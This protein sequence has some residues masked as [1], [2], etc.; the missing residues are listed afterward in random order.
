MIANGFPPLVQPFLA[1]YPAIHLEVVTD[2]AHRDIISGRFDAGIR[3]GHRIERDMTIMRML[4]EFRMIV[5]AAPDYLL[6]RPKPFL[7]EDLHAHNCIRYRSPWEGTILPWV[8]AK[9][10]RRIEIAVE[11]PLIVS[12]I[13][14]ILRN[15]LDGVGIGYLPE[16][17]VAAHLAQGRLVA[18]LDGWTN[19]LPGIFLYH[20]SRRQTPM[21]LEV[22]LRFVEKWR[23]RAPVADPVTASD[24]KRS[25]RKAARR[26]I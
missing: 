11:G 2:D 8:L 9:G 24:D 15:A 6:N 13:E 17:M 4:D 14:S 25:K 10:D 19:M 26:V 18:L 5:V 16:P 23:K 12:D 3:L 20:P 1:E 22:F 7:P 21:P